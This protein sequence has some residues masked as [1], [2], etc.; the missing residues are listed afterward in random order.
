[1]LIEIFIKDILFHNHIANFYNKIKKN[2]Y[3]MLGKH[4]LSENLVSM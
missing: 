2:G 3:E 4:F 1:M